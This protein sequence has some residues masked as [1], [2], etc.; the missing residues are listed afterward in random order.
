MCLKFHLKKELT[1]EFKI[2]DLSFRRYFLGME[3]GCST[4]SIVVTQRKYTLNLLKEVGMLGCKPTEVPIDLNHKIS[5]TE[6][7]KSVD[8]ESY[9]RLVGKSIYL[10]HTRHDITLFVSVVS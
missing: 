6:V 2:K 4:T 5:L 1:R 3:V 9:Q 10:S 8:K 7:G